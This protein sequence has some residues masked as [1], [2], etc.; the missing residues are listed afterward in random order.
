[1]LLETITDATHD[2]ARGTRA[3]RYFLPFAIPQIRFARQPGPAYRCHAWASKIGFQILLR[4]TARGNEL[5]AHVA[6]RCRKRVD[7]VDSA[8]KFSWK[9][10]ERATAKRKRQ[11]DFACGGHP[12]D[13][14]QFEF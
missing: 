3:F 2:L 1:M 11:F 5:Y 9:K 10:L 12:G 4:H 13:E 14:R 7:R 6:V 8:E